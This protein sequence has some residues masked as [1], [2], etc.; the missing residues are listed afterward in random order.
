MMLDVLVK[1]K[2]IVKVFISMLVVLLVIALEKINSYQLL[3]DL[4]YYNLTLLFVDA[5][6]YILPTSVNMYLDGFWF[7]ITTSALLTAFISFYAF[8]VKKLGGF[9]G[10]LVF[11]FSW[12]ILSTVHFISAV[13]NID[14]LL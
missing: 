4:N 11:F 7:F 6:Y 9:R 12:L 14:K 8:I 2:A 3:N 5:T 13:S 10:R 1:N